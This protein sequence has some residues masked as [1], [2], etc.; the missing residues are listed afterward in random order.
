MCRPLIRTGFALALGLT[1]LAAGAGPA[2]V[3]VGDGAIDGRRIQP[4]AFTWR[5]CAAN[6][7]QWVAGGSIT[8]RAET[9]TEEDERYLRLEQV[10]RRPDGG[11]STAVTWLRR[12][13][14]APVRIDVRAHNADGVVLGGAHYT[15]GE[16]GYTGHKSRGDERKEVAGLLSSNMYHGMALGLP[17]AALSP[18][19][20]LPVELAA[21]MVSFDASYRVIATSAGTEMLDIDGRRVEARLVDVEWHHKESG[22]VYPPG[23]D[24]SGGRYWIVPDPPA[25]V[26]Y[27]PRYQTDTY[28]VEFVRSVC[29]E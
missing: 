21:S 1:A 24:A 9:V 26:P 25:G 6:E 4:Y 12:S 27:V 10:T 15:L 5:Q 7:G 20:T 18:N 17:L 19:R 16:A 11:G 28:A 3:A 2:G 8:E 23:P 13:S 14:L 22:D 29:P